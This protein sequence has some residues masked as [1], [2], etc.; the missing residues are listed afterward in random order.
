M[1][2]FE[3]NGGGFDSC[4]GYHAASGAQTTL[5]IMA[6]V[7][8]YIPKGGGFVGVTYRQILLKRYMEASPEEKKRIQ[9][10]IHLVYVKR[11]MENLKKN[12]SQ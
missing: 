6:R 4:T 11:H 9:R 2:R 1:F 10:L 12:N 8:F 5:V 7:S 3:R